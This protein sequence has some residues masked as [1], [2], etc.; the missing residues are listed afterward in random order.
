MALQQLKYVVPMSDKGTI[1]E[2]AS[3]RTD[4][5]LPSELMLL[6]CPTY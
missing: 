2:E 6:N 4:I 3:T 5:V 1:S